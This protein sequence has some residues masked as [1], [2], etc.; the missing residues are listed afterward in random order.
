MKKYIALLVISLL[1][2]AGIFFFFYYFG[3][4][5][6]KALKEFSRAYI[7]YDVAISDLSTA[8]FASNLE[9]TTITGDLEHKADQALEVL[10]LKAS[11]RISSLT[12][13]D[14]ELMSLT[15]EIADLSGK[16]LAA[17]KANQSSITDMDADLDM[18]AKQLNDLTIQRQAAFA[19]FQE[20]SGY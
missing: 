6:T 1:G 3:H 14:P 7:N 10:N 19:R 5:D 20:L 11:V 2:V 16:E 9:G 8:V 18:L 17:L 4:H 12:R 13:N 15:Q